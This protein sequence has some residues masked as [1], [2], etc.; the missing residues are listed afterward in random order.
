VRGHRGEVWIWRGGTLRVRGYG[1]EG[2]M[3]SY[4]AVCLM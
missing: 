1:A 2:E 4:H 3:E